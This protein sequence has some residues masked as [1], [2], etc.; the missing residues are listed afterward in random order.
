MERTRKYL[1]KIIYKYTYLYIYTHEH[2]HVYSC[3]SVLYTPR[4]E[5]KENEREMLRKSL[6]ENYTCM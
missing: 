4:K 2:I 5:G 3:L 6:I 1:R